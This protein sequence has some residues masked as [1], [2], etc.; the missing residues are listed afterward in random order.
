M[1][2]KIFFVLLIGVA[3]INLQAQ[4][5]NNSPGNQK[6]SVRMANTVLSKSDSLIYYVDQNPKWAY[7]VALLG[8]AVDR[9]GKTDPKYS[10]YMEAWVDHFVKPDGSVTDYRLKEYNLDRIFP[11]RNE[12]Y[13]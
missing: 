1:Y 3:V 2:R 11:G 12:F 8:M 6:W 4:D 9:L 13:R 7:D 5:R 10:K